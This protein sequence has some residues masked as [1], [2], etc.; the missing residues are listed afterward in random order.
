M[1][2]SGA[3]LLIVE[4]SWRNKTY[5]AH[6][7]LS[8]YLY[9]DIETDKS[10]PPTK[11]HCIVVKNIGTKE[12]W[13]FYDGPAIESSPRVGGVAIFGSFAHGYAVFGDTIWVGHNALSFDFPATNSLLG[14]SIPIHSIVDTLVLSYLYDPH[15]QGGHS[16]KAWGERTGHSKIEHDEW[17][18]FSPAMLARCEGDVELGIEV[19]LKL[20]RVMA[21]IGFSEKSCQLEHEIRDVINK[22]QRNGFFFNIPRATS[23]LEELR[24]RAS[25]LAEPVQRL[26]PPALVPV[27]TFK[28]RIRADGLPYKSYSSHVEKYPVVER[29]E[30]GTYTCFSWKEFNLGSPQQRLEK[31]L[32]LGWDPEN[33]GA[34]R[35]KT[36][37]SWQVDEDAM[38]LFLER[39][40]PAYR[41]AVEA[42][43]NWIVINGRANMVKTWLDCVNYT[44]SCIHGQVFTC[45]AASRRMTHANPNT[46]NIP[47]AKKSIQY[48]RE[49]RELWRARPGRVL[50]G[51]D[52]KSL[53]MLMFCH[54]LNDPEVTKLY[55]EGDPHQKNADAWGANPWGLPVDRNGP[56][57]AKT[58]FYAGLYGAWDPKLGSSIWTNGTKE[59]G[60]WARQKLY[61]VTPG[62]ERVVDDFQ[63]QYNATGG[64][65]RTIDG[66]F[67]RAKS[68]SAALNY[69]C[70][71]A[72][73]IV[74]KQ[75][76]IFIDRT[77]NDLDHLKVG[78]IHDEGQHDTTREVA[79]EFGRRAV[80]AIRDA[81]E[82]LNFNVP[83]DGDFKI[84]ETWADT[85]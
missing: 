25:G 77:C 79:E 74:M 20:T 37:K 26:F 49:C 78:D 69:G 43:A 66:G 21:R 58:G 41:E 35:T 14:T 6:K 5:L 34:K 85:H 39:C 2:V 1:D 52:A 55:L 13:R 64:L 46:A 19:F 9:V 32:E 11:I 84:G 18:T 40:D 67:V 56:P 36:G 75:A 17:E 59:M 44:D 62:L 31:L 70:Q 28:Y 51:Y 54:Y 53:E 48:G 81:G 4:F 82:E 10:I 29:S 42:L 45:G 83:L 68:P 3:R 73:G 15:L 50:V 38:N 72:G 12:I 47:K 61:E 71:S 8:K 7:D 60:L 30:D 65:I 27:E 57:G 63:Q 24:G 16:L 23:L 76:S 80:E 22:Q 33:M